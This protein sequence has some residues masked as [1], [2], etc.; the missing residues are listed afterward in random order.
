MLEKHGPRA[1][2]VAQREQSALASRERK[3]EIKCEHSPFADAP[4]ALTAGASRY[5]LP[6]ATDSIVIW[7]QHKSLPSLSKHAAGNSEDEN[8]HHE[9]NDAQT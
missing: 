7:L 1:C 8:C 9:H 4:G 6:S 2:S 5:W 3:R